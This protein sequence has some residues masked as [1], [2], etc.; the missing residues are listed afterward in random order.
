MS[1]FLISR[2]GDELGQFKP[3]I[4]LGDEPCDWLRA[5]AQQIS[6]VVL[7]L[8]SREQ[9]GIDVIDLVFPRFFVYTIA[10]LSL[11]NPKLVDPLKAI[12]TKWAS[13]AD[14]IAHL[15]NHRTINDTLWDHLDRCREAHF[16][17]T[18]TEIRVE[19]IIKLDTLCI[20]AR[21]LVILRDHQRRK[22]LMDQ[23]A[24]NA[25]SLLDLFQALLDRPNLG[26]ARP[27]IVRAVVDLSRKTGLYPECLIL[28]GVKI[29]GKE[30]VC[31]GSFGDIYKGKVAGQAIAIKVMRVYNATAIEG[32][33]K[34][35]SR[36]AVLWRQLS[37]PNVLPFYGV[38]RSPETASKLCLVSPWM[39]NGNITQYLEK[40]PTADRRPLVMDIARGL[41]YLHSFEPPVVHGDLRGANVLITPSLRA[42][43]ADFGLTTL[44][45]DVNGPFTPST[46]SYGVGAL[47]WTAPELLSYREGERQ[48]KSLASDMYSFGCVCYEIYTGCPKFVKLPLPRAIIAVTEGRQV[49]R[50]THSELDDTTWDLIEQC[51]AIEPLSRP[52]S[53]EVVHKLRSYSTNPHR[54]ESVCDWN[55]D[56]ILDL[57]SK[58]THEPSDTIA[59]SGSDARDGSQDYLSSFSGHSQFAA[60]TMTWTTSSTTSLIESPI[61]IN[62]DGTWPITD[63]DI[64]VAVMGPT[65]TGKSSFIN[66]A[67]QKTSS[68]I[69]HNLESC[70]QEVRAFNCPHPRQRGRNV[71]FVDTPGFDDT[72]R[73]DYDI[74]KDI[75]KWLETTY[76]QRITLSG[77]LLFHSISES[78]MRGAPLRNLDMFQELCGVNALQ[79]VVLT[80]TMWDEVPVEVGAQREDQ[81]RN[82]FWGPMISHGCRI[83]RFESTWESAWDIIGKFDIAT[84]KPVQLQVQ[85][86]DKGL[87]LP[88][89]SAYGVLTRWWEAAIAKLKE[90]LQKRGGSAKSRAALKQRL[91]EAEVQ[92]QALDDRHS[93]SNR[94]LASTITAVSSRKSRPWFGNKDISKTS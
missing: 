13:D 77:I 81:L 34:V 46:S 91:K 5:N 65:G 7:T 64:I 86:V 71:V 59:S 75:A 47:F 40:T 11:F 43:V 42:C 19:N 70:T 49:P 89:T 57:Y 66:A 50:P 41:D 37:N 30:P 14:D 15:V 23:Q 44:E 38:Y 84:R 56:I 32:A 76:R 12:A 3:A 2:F 69:G 21:I 10:H 52:V 39:E 62:E 72:H 92:K 88:Q 22:V 8:E 63:Q 68:I 25:Q 27:S 36:E 74:L 6:E 60:S 29:R 80:T 90:L 18:G 33:I 24:S 28:R 53:S 82:E 35:F 79:N 61:S 85:L 73:T 93:V 58:L 83:A 78:R 31:G 16:H 45:H 67:T 51:W 26:S 1:D 87:K 17:D 20:T 54:K 94:S 4:S 9:L 48:R 55:E